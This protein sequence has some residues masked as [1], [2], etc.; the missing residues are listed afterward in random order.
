MKVDDAVTVAEKKTH[1][2]YISVGCR[3]VCHE[4]HCVINLIFQCQPA[5]KP[6]VTKITTQFSQG[7]KKSH[8]F[9]Y[10]FK[11]TQKDL[12]LTTLEQKKT[13]FERNAESVQHGYFVDFHLHNLSIKRQSFNTHSSMRLDLSLSWDLIWSINV[14]FVYVT[15]IQKSN[16][17]S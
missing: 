1:V 14:Y 4:L 9:Y 15:C 16:N 11:C 13:K 6:C 8:P 5:C 2:R 17:Q 10:K 3:L 7:Y 12:E